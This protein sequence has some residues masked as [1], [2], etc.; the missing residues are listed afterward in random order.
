[1]TENQGSHEPI[2]EFPQLD[3]FWQTV[4]V[5]TGRFFINGLFQQKFHSDAPGFGHHWVS[6]YSADDGSY[7]PVTYIHATVSGPM[8]LIGGAMTDGEALARM[9]EEHRQSIIDEGGCYFT[10]L[11]HVFVAMA[12]QCEAY[13][14]IIADPRSME[15]SCAAGFEKT[16]DEKLVAYFPKPTTPKRQEELIQAALEIGPF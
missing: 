6:F 7:W 9:K 16:R 15:V 5:S 13:M 1:T 11:R 14:A 3:G 4:D 12:N 8:I 2:N 10:A